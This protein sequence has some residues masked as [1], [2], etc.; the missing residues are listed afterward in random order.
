[1]TSA[2][3]PPVMVFAADDP[4]TETDWVAFSADASMF[5]NPLTDVRSPKV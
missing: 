1:M 3:A 4:S 2:P 5:W